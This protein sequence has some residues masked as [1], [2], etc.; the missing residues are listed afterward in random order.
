[1]T[2]RGKLKLTEAQIRALSMA[3]FRTDS[4]ETWRPDRGYWTVAEE[5]RRSGHLADAG[6]SAM[7]PH[8][9]YVITPLGRRTLSEAQT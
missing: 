4:N 5:L 8:K 1:M 7:P 2:T 9:L 3:E 6:I